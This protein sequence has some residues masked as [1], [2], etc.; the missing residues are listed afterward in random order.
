[1]GN[2]YVYEPTN[3][4]L[5][6]LLSSKSHHSVDMSSR[7]RDCS[8]CMW[9]NILKKGIIQHSTSV[10]AEKLKWSHILSDTYRSI[11]WMDVAGRRKPFD[12]AIGTA[13]VE[14]GD[15]ITST[16]ASDSWADGVDLANM[17]C[18]T[19]G[20]WKKKKKLKSRLCSGQWKIACQKTT[21]TVQFFRHQNYYWHQFSSRERNSHWFHCAT[22]HL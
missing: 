7:H 11:F 14:S 6:T 18:W 16:G 4:R 5:G 15:E 2:K 20:L 19:L 1:M 22:D 12:A 8:K 3:R 17:R 21:F 13:I 10:R 9:Q